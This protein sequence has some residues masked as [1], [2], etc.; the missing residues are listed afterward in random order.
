M[1]RLPN[2]STYI[3]E[4]MK[5]W[6]RYLLE[7]D[8]PA[9]EDIPDIGLY[10]DQVISLLDGY[11]DYLAPDIKG[12]PLATKAMINN[13]V[14]AGVVPPSVKKRYYRVHLAHLIIICLL[15]QSLSIA[16]IAQALP[17]D[18]PED[19]LR[20]IYGRF[21]SLRRSSAKYFCAE[22]KKSVAALRGEERLDGYPEIDDM[23]DLIL[24]TSIIGGYGVLLAQKLTAE[25]CELYSGS[26]SNE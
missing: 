21:S 16:E 3:D 11:F 12:T 6:E 18:L 8:L 17:A 14:Q 19:R 5:V 2:E 25:A 7:Y 13:Y 10:M 4:K 23:D 22:V 9:W 24:A 15:K 26:T 20:S 1:E